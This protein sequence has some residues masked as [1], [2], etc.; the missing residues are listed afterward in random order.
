MA[1]LQ[2]T[3]E[4]IDLAEKDIPHTK[5]DFYRSID[6]YKRGLYLR[7]I[8]QNHILKAAFFLPEYMRAGGTKPVYELFIDRKNKKFITYDV[9]HQKWVNAKLDKLSWP[10]HLWNCEIWMKHKEAD[11]VKEF[12]N[13]KLGGFKGLLEYQWR[14]RAEELIA[15]HKKETDSWDRDLAQVPALPKNWQRWVSKVGIPENYIYYQYERKGAGTGYCTYCEKE[16]PIKKP[17]HNELP[18]NC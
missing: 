10:Y 14:I 6:V 5:K 13:T 12:L 9:L 7:C 4:M 8:I 18:P 17:R 11:A 16:V 2:A 15:R 3:P 1:A